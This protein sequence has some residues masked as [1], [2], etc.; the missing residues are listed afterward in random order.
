MNRVEDVIEQ[1]FISAIC[2]GDSLNADYRVNNWR[3]IPVLVTDLF[4]VVSLP[5]N[6]N[7]PLTTC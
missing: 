7:I 3:F 4:L 1:L 6:L 2:D 5:V